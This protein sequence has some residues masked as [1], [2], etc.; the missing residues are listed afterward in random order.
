MKTLLAMTGILFLTAIGSGCRDVVPRELA[1]ARVAMKRA[2]KRN[3][4]TLAPSQYND[5]KALLKLAERL[6]RYDPF[7]RRAIDAAYL[8]HRQALLANVQADTARYAMKKAQADRR[9]LAARPPVYRLAPDKWNDRFTTGRIGEEQETIT[10]V[11]PERSPPQ[12]IG[13]VVRD[14]EAGKVVTFPARSLFVQGKWS[15]TSGALAALDQ[16]ADAIDRDER[17]VAVV[18]IS[19]SSGDAGL[20]RAAYV[21]KELALRGVAESRVMI[22][23]YDDTAAEDTASADVEI[24]LQLAQAE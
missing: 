22:V 14:S 7:S 2:D 16:V 21:R 9:R 17:M 10:A 3:A 12:E 1:E 23:A 8:A 15:P 19:G 4:K 20:D 11:V 6:H 18:S 5:A 13:A 24:L